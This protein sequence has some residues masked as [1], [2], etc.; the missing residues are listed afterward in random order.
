ML[1]IIGRISKFSYGCLRD[2]MT[3]KFINCEYWSYYEEGIYLRSLHITRLDDIL[4][5][6][7]LF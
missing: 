3:I 1:V 6:V 7:A 2:A 4:G 5:C